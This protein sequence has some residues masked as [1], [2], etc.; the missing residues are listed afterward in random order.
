MA[1]FVVKQIPVE[2]GDVV[3]NLA[4]RNRSQKS[5][6]IGRA[7][8]HWMLSLCEWNEASMKQSSEMNDTRNV[9]VSISAR[10][11]SGPQ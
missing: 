3:A 1:D 6:E 5:R 4:E 9:G 8:W 7:V 10:L 2:I 11:I